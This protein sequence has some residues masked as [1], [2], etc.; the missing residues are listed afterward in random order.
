[1]F[2]GFS[3]TLMPFDSYFEQCCALDSVS[4]RF[5]EQV[6][7]VQS[8]EIVKEKILREI[9]HLYFRVRAHHRCKTYMDTFRR[10]T[11]KS[12]KEKGLR[13]QLK[14]NKGTMK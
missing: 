2:I 12:R 1:M 9:I 4:T 8:E 10:E 6:Y 3:D 11:Q 14:Q 13:K 5:Y 7:S